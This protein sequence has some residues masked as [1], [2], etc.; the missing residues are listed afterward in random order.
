MLGARIFYGFTR[1]VSSQTI[2][3]YTRSGWSQNIY[4]Y[5]RNV[6]S[7]NIY[8]YT[9]NVRSQNIYGCTGSA[10]R[11]LCDME[12]WTCWHQTWQLWCQMDFFWR[13]E[14]I[15]VVQQL[16]T[17]LYTYSTTAKYANYACFP[18]KSQR[19]ELHFNK[20]SRNNAKSGVCLCW[21]E[22]KFTM[23]LF[24]LKRI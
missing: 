11:R 21:K 2:H 24:I 15:T 16:C 5:T 10:G 14:R 18:I 13:K 1:N 8:G 20:Y 12:T 9:R 19:G 4:G 7:Q 17:V 6:R 22:N 23:C 3:G